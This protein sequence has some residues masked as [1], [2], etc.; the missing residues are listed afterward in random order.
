MQRA[1]SYFALM[2]KA[3]VSHALL[4]MVAQQ[5]PLALPTCIFFGEEYLACREE[6]A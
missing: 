5:L 6:L 3:K 1:M 2:A 4:V